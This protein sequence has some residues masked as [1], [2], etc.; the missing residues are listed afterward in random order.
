MSCWLRSKFITGWK[1]YTAY[2]P[3]V[4][5]LQK[6][7]GIFLSCLAYSETQFGIFCLCGLGNTG[8]LGLEPMIF[9]GGE[10]GPGVGI[11]IK[12]WTRGAG[13]GV[14]FSLYR[15]RRIAF[16]KLKVYSDRLIVRL[17]PV[18]AGAYP[19][20]NWC[21]TGI[22]FK[23]CEYVSYWNFYVCAVFCFKRYS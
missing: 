18:K 5:L 20:F 4:L 11:M 16:I 19:M 13:A 14:K 12:H 3:V 23:L 22:F 9:T 1:N 6:K 17:I 2:F 21:I 8:G 10:A 15:S 7:F